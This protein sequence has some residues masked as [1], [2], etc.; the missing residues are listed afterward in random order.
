ML[1]YC[2]LNNTLM[3]NGAYPKVS[4]TQVDFEAGGFEAVMSTAM[5]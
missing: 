5:I 4:S 1:I 2:K 3:L